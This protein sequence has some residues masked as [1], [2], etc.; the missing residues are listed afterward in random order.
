[1]DF[2]YMF[3]SEWHN[4]G[5]GVSKRTCREFRIFWSDTSQHERF[6]NLVVEEIRFF[7]EKNGVE[8]SVSC[9]CCEESAHIVMTNELYCRV[10]PQLQGIIMRCVREFKDTELGWTIPSLLDLDT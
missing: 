4:A 6:T 5:N 1:M 7:G 9:D 3:G 10:L 8:V 2:E